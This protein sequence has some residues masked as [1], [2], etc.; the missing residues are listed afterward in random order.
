MTFNDWKKLH[1]QPDTSVANKTLADQPC[2]PAAVAIMISGQLQRFVYKDQT[3]PLLAPAEC[4]LVADVYIALSNASSVTNPYQLWIHD[5]FSW[6]IS[7]L[8]WPVQSVSI[9]HRY[10]GGITETPY[11]NSTT[12][13]SIREWYLN[14]GAWRVVVKIIDEDEFEQA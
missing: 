5:R 2:S 7:V 8:F 4:P 13:A 9:C 14:R 10:N 1:V 6:I 3:G 11:F 12:T